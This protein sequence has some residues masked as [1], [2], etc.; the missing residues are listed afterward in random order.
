MDVLCIGGRL[1]TAEL[2]LA[3]LLELI[4]KSVPKSPNE[5]ILLLRPKGF[6]IM[7]REARLHCRRS[8][9]CSSSSSAPDDNTDIPGR[10]CFLLGWKFDQAEG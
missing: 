9:Q 5:H 4:P 7:C 6:A 10:T 8:I 2:K 3:L 1:Y